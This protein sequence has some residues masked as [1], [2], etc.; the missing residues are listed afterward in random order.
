MLREEPAVQAAGLT[1]STELR[2]YLRTSLDNQHTLRLTDLQDGSVVGG[3]SG[4]P[5]SDSFLADIRAY[6]G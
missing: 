6:A 2:E 1:H 4:G 5:I 3:A